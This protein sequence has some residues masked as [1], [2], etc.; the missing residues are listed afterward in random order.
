MVANVRP[1]IRQFRG[2]MVTSLI[3]A[4]GSL[5]ISFSTAPTKRSLKR[6][7]KANDAKV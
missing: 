5:R 4:A 7:M 1:G 6:R 2:M 3:L